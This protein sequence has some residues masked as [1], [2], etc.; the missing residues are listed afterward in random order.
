[1]T[2]YSNISN[3]CLSHNRCIQV[4]WEWFACIYKRTIK[5]HKLFKN[6]LKMQVIQTMTVW[7]QF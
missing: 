4:F 3:I 5:R 6:T 2:I 1:M 7:I